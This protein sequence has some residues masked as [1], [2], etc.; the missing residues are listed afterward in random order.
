MGKVKINI[1]AYVYPR[2]STISN[3]IITRDHHGSFIQVRNE[4]HVGNVSVYEAEARAVLDAL[5]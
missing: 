5:K 1:D 4:R 3:G 2:S